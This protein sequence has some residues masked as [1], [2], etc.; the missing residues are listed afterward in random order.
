MTRSVDAGDVSEDVPPSPTCPE[1]PSPQHM[2]RRSSVESL[3]YSAHVVPPPEPELVDTETS[4]GVQPATVV[5][6][7]GSSE[8]TATAPLPS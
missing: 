3:E 6:L 5:T 2:T 7:T 4:R 8:M 1:D